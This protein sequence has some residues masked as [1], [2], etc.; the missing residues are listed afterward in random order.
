[1]HPA[2]EKSTRWRSLLA[3]AVFLPCVA[4]WAQQAAAPA[5]AQSVQPAPAQ[6]API[7]APPTP[8]DAGTDKT[9]QQINNQVAEMVAMS[10]ALK[11]EVGKST[12]DELSVAVI[13]KAAQIE[14]LARRLRA[15]IQPSVPSGK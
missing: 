11:S 8:A 13:R 3:C 14:A 12:K 10:L 9:R 6:T 5:P 7:P 1:M 15:Q 4:A 2:T